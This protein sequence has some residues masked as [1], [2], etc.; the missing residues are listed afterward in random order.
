ESLRLLPAL[1]IQVNKVSLEHSVPVYADQLV[2]TVSSLSQPS[3]NLL[4]HCY[5]HCYLKIFGFQAGLTSLDSEGSFLPLTA[6]V[7]SFSTAL[8]GKVLRLPIYW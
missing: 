5:A 3:D 1:Q 2:S 6:I 4:H 8:Y 7:A